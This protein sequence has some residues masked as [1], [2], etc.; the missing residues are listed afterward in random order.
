[1]DVARKDQPLPSL[2]SHS[3]KVSLTDGTLIHILV[4][5][6]TS[7]ARWAGADGPA[8]HWV[9]VADSIL[10]TGVADTGVIQMAQ[11]A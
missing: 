3:R 11:K 2:S 5:C 6:S 1:M 4:T 8:I 7:E 10:M 9:R